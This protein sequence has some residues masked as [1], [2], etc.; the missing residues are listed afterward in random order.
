MG[1]G[2]T[3]CC[4]T[5]AIAGFLLLM[6]AMVPTEQTLDAKFPNVIMLTG[7]GAEGTVEPISFDNSSLP[8]L[9]AAEAAG[10]NGIYQFDPLFYHKTLDRH[11]PWEDRE[12]THVFECMFFC[13]PVNKTGEQVKLALV[14]TSPGETKRNLWYLLE[15]HD[16]DAN[17][18][19]VFARSKFRKHGTYRSPW[20]TV[21]PGGEIKSKDLKEVHLITAWDAFRF[22]TP[23]KWGVTAALVLA[24]VVWRWKSKD[25]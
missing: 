2:G 4:A 25:D 21:T 9:T 7:M 1:A 20:V 10:L 6:W 22:D 16:G 3:A 15:M 5:F 11:V 24:T 12:R 8:P 13:A 18:P 23:V 14:H 17:S 19:L